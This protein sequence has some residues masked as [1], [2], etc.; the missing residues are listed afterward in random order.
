MSQ[1]HA[2]KKGNVHKNLYYPMPKTLYEKFVNK[3]WAERN[4]IF[5]SRSAFIKNANKSCNESSD[6]ERNFFM[7]KAAP[8]IKTR[9]NHFFKP[10]A[11]ISSSRYQL[12]SQL[13][14]V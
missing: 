13:P 7:N 6:S 9:I 2:N 4:D 1:L 8:A 10:A 11:I 5:E 14:Q 3:K 12:P